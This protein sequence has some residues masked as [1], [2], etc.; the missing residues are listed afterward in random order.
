[1]HINLG[2]PTQKYYI[3]PVGKKIGIFIAALGLALFTLIFTSSQEAAH[4]HLKLPEFELKRTSALPELS[5]RRLTVYGKVREGSIARD[6]AK[7]K[8]VIEDQ[9]LALAIEFTGKTL[10][11]DTF[12]DG[13]NAGAEGRYDAARQVFVADKVMAQCAS[14]YES[15]EQSP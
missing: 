6:G 8:F 12:K 14:R 10:L 3:V 9:K 4:L 11:P 7:A 13:A 15:V 1:M 5:R 2:N